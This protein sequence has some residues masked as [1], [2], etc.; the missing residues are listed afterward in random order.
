MWTD[1]LGRVEVRLGLD[2]VERRLQRLGARRSAGRLEELP[3]Q[4]ASE[5]LA[6]HRPGLAVTVD[7]EIG[8][9]CAVGRVEQLG[10]AGE[11]DQDVGLGRPPPIGVA[12]LLADG[13][14]ER[15]HAAAGL[16]QLR[17]QRLEGGAVFLL[18]GREAG[19]NVGREGRAGIA[20]G[21]LDQ[22]FQRIADLLGRL[23]RRDD[24]VLGLQLLGDG[25]HHAP[26][27]H[28][29]PLA[30]QHV[31]EVAAL[32]R[33]GDADTA[34]LALPTPGALAGRRLAGLVAVGQHDDVAHVDRQIEGAQARGRERRPG[35]MA[36]RLHGGEAGLDA[37]SHHQR[38]ARISEANRAAAA[39]AE[40]HLRGF[41]R[42]LAA[43]VAGEKGA[44][45]RQRP[46]V[47]PGVTS[48]TIA[49]QR[50]PDGMLQAAME[51]E[52]RR[53]RDRQAARGEVRRDRRPC[54]RQGGAPDG[55]RGIGAPGVVAIR[56]GLGGAHPRTDARPP[57]AQ[58]PR[59]RRTPITRAWS[60]PAWQRISTLPSSAA[61]IDRLG[62]RSSWAGQ[63]AIQPPPALRPPRALAMVSAVI[64]SICRLRAGPASGPIVFACRLAASNASISGSR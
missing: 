15:S 35:R 29:K 58:R 1:A 51:A 57:S 64:T 55:E 30:P 21:S 61:R 14:V 31:V 41:D 13:V 42:R 12:V 23:D 46:V 45:D 18:Q 9:G 32:R 7:V 54:G 10:G 36:G 34:T 38:F 16:L 50:P 40:H 39:G 22:A 63:R 53:R 2:H 43:A 6:A 47:R 56:L 33:A 3:R 49:G 20:G 26:A 19:E 5:A 4:P 37:L 24:Q 11:V 27:S 62:S 52:R 59:D 44:V 17:A 25:V 8:E 60:Q 28:R 48:A